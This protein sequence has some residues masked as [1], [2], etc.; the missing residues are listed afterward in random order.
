MSWTDERIEVLRK[1]WAEGHSASQIATT[2]GGVSRNAVIGKIHR[3]GLSGRVKATK[4]RGSTRQRTNPAPAATPASTPSAAV[5]ARAKPQAAQPRAMA[6]GSTV[7]KVVER[8]APAALMAQLPR[9]EPA[10]IVP[11]HGKMTLL[12]LG[13]SCCRWP[14]GDP[15]DSGFRFCGART[16]AGAVYCSAHADIAFPQRLKKGKD[17]PH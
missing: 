2:L 10:D 9:E 1:L 7:V 6:V 17:R 5:I 16:E 12:D 15:S 3:L 13:A 8:E 4:P 14:I 11:L